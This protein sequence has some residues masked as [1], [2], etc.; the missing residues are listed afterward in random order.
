MTTYKVIT[1]TDFNKE[2]MLMGSEYE[3]QEFT[4][5]A[6][7]EEQA[8]EKAKAQ[9]ILGDYDNFVQIYYTVKK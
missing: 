2:L 1:I 6:E 4:I 7:T 9:T 3:T 8:E 5:Q